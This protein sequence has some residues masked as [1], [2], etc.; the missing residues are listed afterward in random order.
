MHP[1]VK[2]LAT[3]MY[4]IMWNAFWY[5]S[6]T[7]RVIGVSVTVTFKPGTHYTCSRPVNTSSELSRVGWA[8]ARRCEHQRHSTPATL[9]VIFQS[10]I[11]Q[12]C[13]F[14]YP[15]SIGV[16]CP[17]RMAT[18]PAILSVKRYQISMGLRSNIRLCLIMCVRIRG[19]S[20]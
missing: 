17:C 20:I 12:S 1:A 19:D 18:T 6:H 3:P 9:S 5:L 16:Y 11:F 2:I 7:N 8:V 15:V 10:C 4:L 14:S 13:K